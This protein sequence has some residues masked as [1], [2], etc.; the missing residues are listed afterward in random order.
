[1]VFPIK[2][3]KPL[4]VHTHA[5]MCMCVVLVMVV[6]GYRM[7][8]GGWAIPGQAMQPSGIIDKL[9]S[10]LSDM[11]WE[12]GTCALLTHGSTPLDYVL[13]AGTPK[14]H[15]RG[16]LH[17]VPPGLSFKGIKEK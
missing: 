9:S 15:C 14:G 16:M 12:P 13:S 3:A 10:T 6:G 11:R 8:D 4:R 5:C 1:M 7:P 17:M 2:R